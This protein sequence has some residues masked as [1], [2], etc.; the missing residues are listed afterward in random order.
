MGAA[1][2]RLRRESRRRSYR[3]SGLAED[4]VELRAAD[5]ADALRHP[6][7]RVAHLDLSGELALLL[8]LHAVRLAAVALG[9]ED[10]LIVSGAGLGQREVSS[11]RVARRGLRR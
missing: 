4:A 5:G 9:H 6:P 3:P 2:D 8:A 7:A 11:C 10:L 1:P